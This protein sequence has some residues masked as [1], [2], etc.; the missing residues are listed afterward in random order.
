MIKYRYAQA[1][2]ING[3]EELEHSNFS[4]AWSKQ[5]LLDSLSQKSN[6]IFVAVDDSKL[7]GYAIIMTVLDESELYR[8][9]VDKEFRGRGIARELMHFILEDVGLSSC[10]MMTLEV[11]KSNEAAIGLYKCLDF[12]EL[13]IRKSYYTNPSEDAVI[14]QK[15]W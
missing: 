13:S 4:D 8:I 6:Y 2:D 3:I 9:A 11:R 12:M 7:I 5:M 10:H 15:T 14:M 1:L